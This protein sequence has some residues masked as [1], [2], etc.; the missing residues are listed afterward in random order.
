MA[1]TV[2][3]IGA[4]GGVGKATARNMVARGYNVIATVSRPEKVAAFLGD[5]P[6]CIRGAALDLADADKTAET[7][8]RLIGDVPR[9]DAVV[10][11]AADISFAPAEFVPLAVFRRAMEV[12]CVAHLAIYQAAMPALRHSRGRLVFISSLSGRVATPLMVSYVASKFALEGLADVMRQEAE[13]WGV[14]VVL[15]QPGSIDTSMVP[16]GLQT[17]AAAIPN[18]PQPE[19][20]LYGDLYR[21]SVYRFSGAKEPSRMRRLPSPDV[22]AEVTI[23]AIE[24]DRPEPRYRIGRDAEFLIEASRTK[25]DREMD[26][27]IAAAYGSSGAE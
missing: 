14:E 23:R 2:I 13:K 26:Q 11:C 5:V 21:Q 16:R 27:I 22:V 9:L 10:V 6:G 18:L 19:A 1:R 17:V 8:G 24:C 12:N 7:V 3:L 20:A 4:G 25:S 15:L